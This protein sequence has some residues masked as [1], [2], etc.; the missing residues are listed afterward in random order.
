MAGKSS[1]AKVVTAF[2]LFVTSFTHLV[3]I[4]LHNDL[5][6]LPKGYLEKNK[7]MEKR[8]LGIVLSLL[9]AAGLIYVGIIFMNGGESTR[10]I[11]AIIF[12]ASFE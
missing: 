11:K 12:T 10:N 3:W 2:R 6:R 4:T 5:L 1:I 9:G 7:L 8:I